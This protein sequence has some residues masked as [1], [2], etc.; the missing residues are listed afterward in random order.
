MSGS[1]PDAGDSRY[2]RLFERLDA[3]IVAFD[4]D[5]DASGRV[6]ELVVLEANAAGRRAFGPSYASSI[7]R[8]AAEL[9]G[10]AAVRPLIAC[11]GRLLNGELAR[12]EVAFATRNRWFAGVVFAIDDRTLLA[13]ADDRALPEGHGITP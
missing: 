2:R 10:E 9:F 13:V 12:T 11:A 7:G 5:R 6:T 1:T 4:V 8:P 3:A